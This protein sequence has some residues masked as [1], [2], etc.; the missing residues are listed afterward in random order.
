M[1]KLIIIVGILALLT[2]GCGWLIYVINQRPIPASAAKTWRINDGGNLCLMA[3]QGEV[4]AAL[5]QADSR[6]QTW[7]DSPGTVLKNLATQQCLSSNG[8]GSRVYADV[9]V[10]GSSYQ[11]WAV[12]N[13]SIRSL[14]VGKC[15]GLATTVYLARC[16]GEREQ[17]WSTGP[18][19]IEAF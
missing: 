19:A 5:C 2:A 16:N 6:E 12:S 17:R 4:S 11:H 14:A 13:G 1:R 7:L 8:D 3:N 9:C 10:D 18:V 15:L